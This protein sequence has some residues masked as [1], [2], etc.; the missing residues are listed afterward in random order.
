MEDKYQM[1]YEKKQKNQV[2]PGKGLNWKLLPLQFIL[3]ILP[4][5]LHLYY[6]N[7]G[8]SAYAWNSPEDFYSDV[9][10]HGKMSAFMIVAV[11]LV[12]LVIYRLLTLDAKDRKK[13]YNIY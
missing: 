6:G 4:F 11:V 2:K 10:L 12:I 3:I 13:R 9:F 7:S 8:Y 1:S 5:I